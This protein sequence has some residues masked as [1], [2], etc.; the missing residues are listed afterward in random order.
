MSKSA[1]FTIIEVLVALLILG[2]GLL[3][4]VSAAGLTTRLIAEGSRDTRGAA[5]VAARLASLRAT[6]CTSLDAGTAL[7]GA[8]RTSWSG[9]PVARGVVTLTVVVSAPSPYGVW[10]DTLLATRSCP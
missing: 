3:A 1:G 2:I 8:F 10:A 4:F 7:R 6:S 5:L 9:T